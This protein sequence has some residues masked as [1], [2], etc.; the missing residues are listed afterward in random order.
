MVGDCK[1][2]AFFFIKKYAYWGSVPGKPVSAEKKG[3]KTSS[4]NS[5]RKGSLIC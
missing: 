3:W 1:L 4:F 5:L 2:L